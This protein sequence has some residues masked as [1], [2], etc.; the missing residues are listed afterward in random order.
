MSL[1][2]FR[3]LANGTVDEADLDL[4]GQGLERG[5]QDIGDSRGLAE[6]GGHLGE[7]GRLAIG[8]VEV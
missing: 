1:P 3:H 6:N 5:F 7:F 4:W 2:M 8:A